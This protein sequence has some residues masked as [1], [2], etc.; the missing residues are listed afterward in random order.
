MDASAASSKVV[1][2]C[3]VNSP[4]FLSLNS[5]ERILELTTSWC[6]ISQAVR[7]NA[8]V[9]YGG[10]PLRAALNWSRRSLRT[11]AVCYM[12]SWR[13]CTSIQLHWNL[14]ACCFLFLL[15]LVSQ[16][17]F[18]CASW[19]TLSVAAFAASRWPKWCLHC[20][21]VSEG[22]IADET[23][24]VLLDSVPVSPCCGAW[25]AIICRCG[26]EEMMIM[27]QSGKSWGRR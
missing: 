17:T 20:S 3:W 4:G 1:K 7:T 26:R 8:L 18:K 14:I 27:K 10:F 6:S 9:D 19:V 25:G 13:P 2:A 24:V 23:A 11:P 5:S 22:G 16:T 12:V 21:W 15:F